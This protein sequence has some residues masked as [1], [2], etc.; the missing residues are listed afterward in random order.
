M[1]IFLITIP[2]SLCPKRRKTI[3]LR[4]HIRTETTNKKKI[5]EAS[6]LKSD[7]T[8]TVQKTKT[9]LVNNKTRKPSANIRRALSAKQNNR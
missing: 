3:N 2:T 6:K 7:I 8:T 5:T 9:S 1:S 4:I